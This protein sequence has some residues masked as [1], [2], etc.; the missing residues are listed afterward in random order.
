[1]I[2]NFLKNKKNINN[3]KKHLFLLE[4]KNPFFGKFLISVLRELRFL[5]YKVIFFFSKNEIEKKDVFK[6]YQVNPQKIKHYY[7]GPF[8]VLKD[9]GAVKNGN[10]DISDKKMEKTK[11]YQGMKERFVEKKEW[12]QTKFY[13]YFLKKI[14]KGEIMWHCINEEQWRAR[15]ENIDILYQNIKM[16][17]YKAQSSKNNR[18]S[19]TYN[20]R[21]DKKYQKIDEVLISI[22]RSGQLIF[23]DGAHRLAIAKILKLPE[24]PVMILIRHKKWI[25][26]KKKLI[27][28]SKLQNRGLYQPAY[29]CDLMD[30]PFTYGLKRFELIKNNTSFLSGKVLDIGSNIGYFCHKFEEI[31]FDCLAI[32]INPEDVYFMK[33]LRDSNNEK[34]QVVQQSIFDYKKGQELNFDIVLALNIF[35][36]FLKREI[37]HKRLKKLLSRIN[38][39]EMFFE[40]H[41]SKESQMKDAYK[42]YNSENFAKFIIDNSSFNNYSLISSFNDGRRLYKIFK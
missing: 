15:L 31:G 25:E 33:K 13:D 1:M 29:H 8:D 20:G 2:K 19:D 22:G 39:K 35:H 26:F 32:E 38:A 27:S 12:Q 41:N 23:N 28:Y 40:A 42:N 10:W 18:V 17:G 36:H 24:I 3:F 4:E 21:A 16:S 7:D 6:I 34:F 11:V 30:I 9:R 37:D 5:F 14:N